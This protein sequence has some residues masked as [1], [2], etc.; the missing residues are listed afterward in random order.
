MT[1]P[2]RAVANVESRVAERRFTLMTSSGV[3]RRVG[4]EMRTPIRSEKEAFRL[5]IANDVLSGDELRERIVGEAREYVEVDVLAP[6]L[7]GRIH[8]GVSDIDRELEAARMWLEIGRASC[9]ER[10]FRTV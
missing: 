2:V 4:P 3:G 6:V 9:R 1:A 7:A 10:V 5:A 8:V